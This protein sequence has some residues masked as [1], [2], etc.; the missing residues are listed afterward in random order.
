MLTPEMRAWENLSGKHFF[1]HAGFSRNL[2]PG[3]TSGDSW[4]FR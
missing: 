1:A 2:R 3:V 4:Q